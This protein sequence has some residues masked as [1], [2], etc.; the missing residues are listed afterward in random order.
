MQELSFKLLQASSE[1]AQW[2]AGG[3]LGHHCN[4]GTTGVNAFLQAGGGT[5]GSNPVWFLLDSGAAVSVFCHN[6]LPTSF[7]HLME[8]G[9]SST[10][11]S[12]GLPL[13]VIG[14][15]SFPVSLSGYQMTHTF[16]VV[17]GLMVEGLLGVDFLEKHKAV[18]DFAECCLTL[19]W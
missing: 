14:E 7:T 8:P 5:I 6:K 9:S 19:G 11:G 13:D 17:N 1:G 3:S 18:I 16:F 10:V 2:L 15:V 12:N 4:P